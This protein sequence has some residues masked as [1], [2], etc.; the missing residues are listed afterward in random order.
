MINDVACALFA[1]EP[2]LRALAALER[3]QPGLLPHDVIAGHGHHALTLGQLDSE[4]WTAVSIARASDVA[5]L[6]SSAFR[7]V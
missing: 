4:A 5:S 1:G 6:S 3:A 7:L 2:Q